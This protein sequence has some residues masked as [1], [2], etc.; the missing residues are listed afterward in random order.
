MGPFIRSENKTLKMMLNVLIAL[1]PIFVF[2]WYNQG[3]VPYMD[4]K[5]NAIGLFYPLI[6]PTIGGLTSF[7]IE[8]IYYRII[9]HNNEYLSSFGFFPGFFL[10]LI[11][12]IKTPIYVLALGSIVAGLSKI[13]FGG[14]GRNI[15]NPA[16]IGYIFITA[17]FSFIFTTSNYSVDAIS[18]ATPLTNATMVSGIGT[19]DEIIK[20]YGSLSN[21]FFGTI[22]GALAETSALLCLVAFIYLTA[23]KT[24]KWRIPVAYV[25]T[26]FLITFGISRMLGVGLYYPL[27]QVLSGG[28]M[29]GA[30]F[31]A[32]DPVTSA[33]TPTGQ[34]FQ[35]ILLGILTVA[36]RFITTEGVATSILIMNMF[37]FMLDK[38]GFKVRF[39]SMKSLPWVLL[40]CLL[41]I[42]SIVTLASKK[43]VVED[44]DPNFN[45]V[46]K[47]LSGNKTIYTATQ[48]GYGGN[49]EAVVVVENDKVVS[50]D[51][52][53]NNETKD[54]YKL[55]IDA[56]YIDKLIKN[57]DNLKDV[58]T[59]SGAT[60]TSTALKKLITNVMED[61][62]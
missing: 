18:Q 42:L 8:F 2:V 52:V 1:I 26:V 44:K 35:G 57:Q 21:F 5:T 58:D 32:T 51:V 30:V 33:V 29:F 39:D 34:V 43:R 4:G 62:N 28:L 59:V 56:D 11:L 20:P 17:C 50:F 24:I 60:V 9:K 31:I 7:V 48:K 37:V 40:I 49:I 61:Y 19:Y 53:S 15:F 55:V 10:G 27:F 45:I 22:P 25:S 41:L 36:I 54:K 46:E 38:I 16:L 47:E 6:F 23:T 12:P 13:V 3:Y 14:F